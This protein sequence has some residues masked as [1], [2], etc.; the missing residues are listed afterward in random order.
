M[1]ISKVRTPLLCGLQAALV[2]L[3]GI[4]GASAEPSPPEPPGCSAFVAIGWIENTELSYKD[5]MHT[6]DSWICSTYSYA[7]VGFKSE[8][9]AVYVGT[10]VSD[11]YCELNKMERGVVYVRVDEKGEEGDSLIKGEILEIS[12]TVRRVKQLSSNV[13]YKWIDT[14][15]KDSSNDVLFLKKWMQA[16]RH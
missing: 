4:S 8:D 6:G 11:Y 2:A 7:S 9:F 10:C 1:P 15:L 5:A 12:D 13:S 16:L 3:I 14:E